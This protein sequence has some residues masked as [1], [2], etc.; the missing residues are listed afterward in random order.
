MI[1][2]Q[3]LTLLCYRDTA[4]TLRESAPSPPMASS[5]RRGEGERESAER[6]D[7][8]SRWGTRFAVVCRVVE[9]V[10]D[11]YLIFEPAVVA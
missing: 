6:R 5:K 3:L 7:S 8:D 11:L 4:P 2:R 10:I 1:R 9:E